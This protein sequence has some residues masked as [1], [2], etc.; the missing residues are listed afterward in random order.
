VKAG[1]PV[2]FVVTNLG[3]V[4][5]ELVVGNRAMQAKHEKEMSSRGGMHPDEMGEMP[6]LEL[7]PGETKS[8]TT[9]FDKPGSPLF[10]CHE[11]GHYKGGMVGTLTITA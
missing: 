11:P 5:H 3:K 7:D 9:T 4:K 8:L 2:C 1:E 6:E 10:A